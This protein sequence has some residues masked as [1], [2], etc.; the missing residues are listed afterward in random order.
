MNKNDAIYN[1]LCEKSNEELIS[2]WNEY[3]ENNGCEED[4]VY[5][6]SDSEINLFFGGNAF[7]ALRAASYGNYD[8]DDAYF[9]I[10]GYNNLESIKDCHLRDYTDCWLLADNPIDTWFNEDELETLRIDFAEFVKDEGREGKVEIDA[11]ADWELKMI[12]TYLEE[13][14]GLSLKLSR[15]MIKLTF[16][17]WG[18]MLMWKMS[19]HYGLIGPKGNYGQST[20]ARYTTQ[21]S[22]HLSDMYSNEYVG[23]GFSLPKLF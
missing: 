9:K 3:S 17:I 12:L 19:V 4:K 21:L 7:E 5:E 1:L 16:A 8:W 13:V 11:I 2:I 10:D 22:K 6:N 20:M 23:E 18:H 15:I 14:V